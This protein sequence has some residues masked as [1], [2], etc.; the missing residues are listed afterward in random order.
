MGIVK[1]Y[2]PIICL[3]TNNTEN[4]LNHTLL[5]LYDFSYQSVKVF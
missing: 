2:F 4:Y 5:Y 3:S 1:K